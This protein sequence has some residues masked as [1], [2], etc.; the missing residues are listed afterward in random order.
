MSRKAKLPIM[1]PKG[2]EAKQ[3]GNLITVKG[4]KGVLSQEVM[5]G[6]LVKIEDG[7]ITV[8]LG[9]KLKEATNFLGL[10]WSLISNMVGGA[11]QGYEKHLE[12]IGVGFR[13]NIQGNLLDLHIGLSHPTK[14]EI[15]QGIEAKV[16]KNTIK[17]TGAD[18]QKVGQFAADVRAK[19]PP[20]PY[21]GK[22]I[23]YKDEY[24]RRKAGKSGKK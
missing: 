10:Y 2:V 13:A 17:I 4:P 20:E 3:E 1:L 14:M 24:V 23:R 21:K 7:M 11:S 9:E 15:P 18:K 6:V 5:D 19:R 22:G 16:E 8:T 12:M